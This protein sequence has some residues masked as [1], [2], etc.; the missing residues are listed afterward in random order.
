MFEPKH[1]ERWGQPL[2]GLL[3]PSY[4]PR[5]GWPWHRINQPTVYRQTT[6]DLVEGLHYQMFEPLA[7]SEPIDPTESFSNLANDQLY[8]RQQVEGGWTLEQIAELFDVTRE[9]VRQIESKALR[10]LR[11]Y[12]SQ[13]SGQTV[14][15][16]GDLIDKFYPV[17]RKEFVQAKQ[18]KMEAVKKNEYPKDVWGNIVWPKIPVLYH[19]VQSNK[20]PWSELRRIDEKQAKEL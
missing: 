16:A 17:P 15:H 2:G 18:A 6:E 4:N 12:F 14:D 1:R 10:K 20:G 7:S 3:N 13:E 19:M 9:R 11:K 8:E 5:P